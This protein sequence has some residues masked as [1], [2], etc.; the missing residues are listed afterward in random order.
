MVAN[1]PMD[2]SGL[3]I[4]KANSQNPA[5]N[6]REGGGG[7]TIRWRGLAIFDHTRHD[8]G[9]P[10]SD[11]LSGIL[12]TEARKDQSPRESLLEKAS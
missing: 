1:I 10:T 3:P 9:H 7:D 4:R 5:S 12:P 11:A 8:R 6:I 2:E